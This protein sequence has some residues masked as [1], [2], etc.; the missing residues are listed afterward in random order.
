MTP[1]LSIVGLGED[2]LDALTPAARALVA[3]AETLIGGARHL[4]L[5]PANGA[6]RL[7]WETPLSRTVE[8]IASRRGTRV[9]VL[10]TSDPMS[11]SASPS[12]VRWTGAAR[13]PRTNRPMARLTSW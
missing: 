11:C 12:S 7:T 1:W 9:C 6:T 8:A 10:A 2:G 13:S 4:A 5:V 3:G